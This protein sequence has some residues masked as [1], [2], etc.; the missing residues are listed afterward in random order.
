MYH[1]YPLYVNDP[2]KEY[3]FKYIYSP[4][5]FDTSILQNISLNC[6]ITVKCSG[7][8][9]NYWYEYLGNHTHPEKKLTQR[10]LL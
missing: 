1:Q 4:Y 2:A 8:F 10:N 6:L 9:F 5:N 7:L 3:F